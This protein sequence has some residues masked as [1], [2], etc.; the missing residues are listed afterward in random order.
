[1][2][3]DDVKGNF[4]GEELEGFEIKCSGGGGVVGS[5]GQSFNHGKHRERCHEVTRDK[6]L[7]SLSILASLDKVKPLYT[8]LSHIA[9]NLTVKKCK[10]GCV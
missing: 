10:Q 5:V 7:L 1:M 8:N 4:I 6:L 3:R 9:S 2:F